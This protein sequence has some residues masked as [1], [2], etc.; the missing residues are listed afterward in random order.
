M[1]SP[2]TKLL[3][4]I[5]LVGSTAPKPKY[6]L[7]ETQDAPDETMGLDAGLKEPEHPRGNKIEPT[8]KGADYW[9][10]TFLTFCDW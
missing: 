8:A 1:P 10:P 6:V 4:L 9:C 5:I 7:I 2:I 3:L